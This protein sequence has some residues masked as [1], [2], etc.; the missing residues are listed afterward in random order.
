M[1]LFSFFYADDKFNQFHLKGPIKQFIYRKV[2]IKSTLNKK[3]IS[4]NLLY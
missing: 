4:R 3:D 1:N 2:H